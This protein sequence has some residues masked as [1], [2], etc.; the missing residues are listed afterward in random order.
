MHYLDENR[1]PHHGGASGTATLLRRE[2]VPAAGTA[3]GRV[4]GT[5]PAAGRP[6]AGAV[7]GRP[8]APDRAPAV[9]V[10]VAVLATD[11]LTAEGAVA[12][13]RSHPAVTPLTRAA[14]GQADVVLILAGAVTEETLAWMQGA[15]EQLSDREMRFVLVGDGVREAQLLRAVSL[16]LVSI[17]PRQGSDYESIV[18]AVLA[19][20]EGRVEMPDVA[21]GWLVGQI[22]SIQRD[23]LAPNGLT[24][25]GLEAREVDV[26]R[27]LADGLDTAEIAEQLSY[28][29]RTVKNIIHGLLSRLKLRNRPHA[30]AYAL[31]HGLL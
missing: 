2:H 5:R 17:L 9:P 22:R 14:V 18:R 21:L 25:A 15:A 27:L 31:R 19:V 16:G 20:R 6:A 12:Y 28:S 10:T 24:A 26:L 30:V 29:Q 8:A 3:A 4:P 11:P 13:L 7:P 1:T 23:V